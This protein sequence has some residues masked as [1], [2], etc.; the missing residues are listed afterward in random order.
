MKGS[1][2]RYQGRD[3]Q[4]RKSEI[5]GR[6]KGKKKRKKEKRRKGDGFEDLSDLVEGVELVGRELQR[7]GHHGA[8]KPSSA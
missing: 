5:G 2:Y 4:E 3:K 8:R 1:R 7:E 6:N